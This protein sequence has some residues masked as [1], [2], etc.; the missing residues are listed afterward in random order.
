MYY[1]V[2]PERLDQYQLYPVDMKKHIHTLI[3]Y[4]LYTFNEYM[5]LKTIYENVPNLYYQVVELKKSKTFYCFGIRKALPEDMMAYAKS[6][7]YWEVFE[8]WIKKRA[9]RKE[10]K[11]MK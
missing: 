8:E 11:K 4:E 3:G 10:L 2:I 5:R 7:D 1:V 6:V 9:I